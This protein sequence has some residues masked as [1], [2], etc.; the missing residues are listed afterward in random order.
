MHGTHNVDKAIVMDRDWY[1]EYFEQDD[2]KKT[3]THV[4]VS[5]KKNGEN[6]GKDGAPP[7]NHWVIFFETSPSHSVC[8]NMV[9]N[10]DESDELRGIVFASTREYDFDRQALHTLSFPMKG[11]PTVE[12]IA[13]IVNKNGL[14]RFR[15]NTDGQGCRFW[16]CTFISHLE[17]EGLVESGCADQTWADAAYYYIDPSGRELRKLTEGTFVTSTE[18]V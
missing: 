1:T 11:T 3:I 7:F 12:D 2:L 9:S 18:S 5:V 13:N 15:F 8:F 10:D 16:V 14:H 17:K 6:Q 4:H